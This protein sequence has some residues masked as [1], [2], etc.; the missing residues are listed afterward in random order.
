MSLTLAISRYDHVRDL[1]ASEVAADGIAL[2]ALELPVE[3]IF[4][5]FLKYQEWEVSELS[6]AKYAALASQAGSP[7]TAIPVFPSR[8]FRQSSIYV[9]AGGPV[10]TPSDLKG[11]RVGIPE[12]AQTA[13]VYSRG[14]LVEDYGLDLAEI[15]WLQAGVNEPG[16]REKVAIKLPPGV[17]LTPQPEKSLDVM[18]LAGEVDAVMSAHAPAAAEAGDPRVSRLFEN[19]REVEEDYWKRTRIFPIMHVIAIR[20]AVVERFPW[21]PMNLMKAFEEAKRRSVRRLVEFTAS[22]YPIP[23]LADIAAR[24]Y[25]LFGGDPFPYGIE[26]NRTT[27]DTFLRWCFEQGVCQRRL[28]P[29][30]LFVPGIEQRF[31]I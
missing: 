23:W 31:K 10:K 6:L 30:D 9:R 27:L 7:F 12:W 15:E 11:R 3:E 1:T 17:R 26:A 16:R 14:I 2:T 28:A 21:V 24:T 19:Y 25:A 22:R 20:R 29:E 5:R 4:H 13:A 18:L 8:F